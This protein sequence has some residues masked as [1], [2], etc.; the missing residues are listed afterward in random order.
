[1]FQQLVPLLRQRSVLLTVTSL[2]EDQIRVN[3]L[4]KKLAGGENTALTIPM[5]FTGTA[6]ELDA[7]PPDAI[8]S[9]V[10]SHLQLKNTLDRAKEE[11]VAA[12]KA[13][14]DEAR[15][16]SKTAKKAATAYVPVT[17]DEQKRSRTGEGTQSL[18]YARPSRG[19]ADSSSRFGRRSRDSGRNKTGRANGERRRGICRFVAVPGECPLLAIALTAEVI[20]C[21]ALTSSACIRQTGPFDCRYRSVVD[22]RIGDL[23]LIEK[24]KGQS[25]AIT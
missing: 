9:F 7:Q 10:A 11:M 19:E 23:A 4:P 2:E 14:Q 25:A 16:K 24:R 21:E 5:S 12:T 20:S 15:N 1:M 6:A 13:V 18:R 22:E 8:V 3:V 17:K